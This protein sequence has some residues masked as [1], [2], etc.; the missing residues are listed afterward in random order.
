MLSIDEPV[1][2]VDYDVDWPVSFEAECE[3]LRVALRSAGQIEHIGSTAVPGLP[4]KPI[5]DIMLGVQIYPPSDGLVKTVA[6]LGYE[7]LGEAGVPERR[8]FRRRG[9]K[10]N[11]NLHVVRHG[12]NQWTSNLALREYLRSSAEARA[13]YVAVKR[14]ALALGATNLLAYSAAKS[15]VLA[16]LLQ[17]ARRHRDG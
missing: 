15:Q 5:I 2:V 14:S 1:H 7:S 9:A 10:E 16:E 4:S 12:G 11:F 6:A 3:R 13:K 8:Y 17:K